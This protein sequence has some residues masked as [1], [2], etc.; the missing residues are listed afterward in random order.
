MTDQPN[1]AKLKAV[2]EYGP[3]VAFL[4]GYFLLKD[5]TFTIAGTAYSGFVAMTALFVPLTIL[6]TA[7]LWKITGKLSVMQI[8][9]LAL[10]LV[11][12]GLTIWLNDERFLKSKPTIIY[13]FFALL[14]GFGLWRGQSYLRLAMEAALPLTQEGWMI[15]T[16]RFALFFLALA[17]AN[18]IVWRAFSTDTWV[19][20]K[21]PGLPILLFLFIMSN[22]KLFETYADKPDTPEK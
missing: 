4:L 19:W 18:E 2:L 17:I 13:L 6:S 14:L 3:L 16:K 8:V 7:L 1:H 20:F 9:T 11:M 15:L 22:F 21:F 12:G 10:V 5:H